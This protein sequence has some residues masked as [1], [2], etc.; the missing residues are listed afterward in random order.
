MTNQGTEPEVVTSVKPPP[1]F[2]V[3]VGRIVILSSLVAFYQYYNITVNPPCV[4]WFWFQ[5]LCEP[6]PREHWYPAILL[7]Y[8]GGFALLYAAYQF[9]RRRRAYALGVVLG[10][11]LSVVMFYMATMIHWFLE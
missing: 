2:R 9:V 1:L 11:V 8:G 4:R 5:E 3:G 6:R 7:I 10:V